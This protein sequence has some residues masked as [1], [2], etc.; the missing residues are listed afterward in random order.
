MQKRQRNNFH[1][2]NALCGG[3]DEACSRYGLGKS[4]MRKVAA[5]AGAIIRIGKRL[6]VN[7]SRVDQYMNSISE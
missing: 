2:E 7:Y 4:T 6:L 5:D 3:I 1:P